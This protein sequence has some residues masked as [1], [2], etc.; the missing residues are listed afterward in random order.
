MKNQKSLNSLLIKNNA[1]GLPINHIRHES[2]I[3]KIPT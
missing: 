3:K 2:S 1:L